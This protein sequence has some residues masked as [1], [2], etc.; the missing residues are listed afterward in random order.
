MFGLL[1]VNYTSVQLFKKEKF[2]SS[3]GTEQLFN[4][5]S[6]S[7]WPLLHCRQ[8][9]PHHSSSPNVPTGLHSDEAAC[10]ACPNHWV[11]GLANLSLVSLVWS[12]SLK[13]LYLL[14][15]LWEYNRNLS[16]QMEISS[17]SHHQVSDAMGK[18]YPH[19]WGVPPIPLNVNFAE[20]HILIQAFQIWQKKKYL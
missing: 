3:P 5:C 15:S 6:L 7:H 11:V 13:S 14:Y 19:L 9:K 8:D 4:K 20:I 16:S 1:C 18:D 17:I 10:C 12:W 2:T